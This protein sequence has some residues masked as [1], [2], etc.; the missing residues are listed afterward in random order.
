MPP[1]SSVAK[2]QQ[3]RQHPQPQQQLQ[4]PSFVSARVN[5]FTTR[6]QLAA[7]QPA[8]PPLGL[9]WLAGRKSSDEDTLDRLVEINSRRVD[10]RGVSSARSSSAVRGR[11]GPAQNIGV[12]ASV[13]SSAVYGRAKL[14]PV[15]NSVAKP[16]STGRNY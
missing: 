1:S 6:N 13:S 2:Q 3:Q 7:V 10:D 14:L 8:R 15:T 12:A 16:F 11:P 4:Q 9:G 5:Q